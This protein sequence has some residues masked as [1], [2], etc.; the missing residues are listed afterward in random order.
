MLLKNHVQFFFL[1]GFIS[2]DCEF[3]QH[4][5]EVFYQRSYFDH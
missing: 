4:T 2:Q 3:Y 1:Q 5:P